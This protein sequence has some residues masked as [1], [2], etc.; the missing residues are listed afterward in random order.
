ML[1]LFK[2][3]E[4]GQRTGS[5]MLLGKFSWEKT[6]FGIFSEGVGEWEGYFYNFQ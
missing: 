3:R 1:K 6:F 2:Q 4:R 5:M